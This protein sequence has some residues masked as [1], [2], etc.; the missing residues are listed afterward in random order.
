MIT[1]FVAEL[2]A[3]AQYSKWVEIFGTPTYTSA[4]GI[5]CLRSTLTTFELPKKHISDNASNLTNTEF[6]RL[7]GVTHVTTTPYHAQSNGLASS[8]P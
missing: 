1:T 5:L 7:N 3:I 4:T 8:I 2:R 6:V